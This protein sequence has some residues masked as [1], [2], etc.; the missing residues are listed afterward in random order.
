MEGRSAFG[1]IFGGYS[2]MEGVFG[3][4]KGTFGVD[5]CFWPFSGEPPPGRGGPSWE[6]SLAGVF[7]IFGGE[8]PG[9]VQVRKRSWPVFLGLLG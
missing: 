6:M 7:G 8:P 9:G 5:R 4:I 3:D 1:G 2:W